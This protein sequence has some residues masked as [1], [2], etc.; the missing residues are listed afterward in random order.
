MESGQP[1]THLVINSILEYCNIIVTK[2]ELKDILSSP[3][4]T[5]FSLSSIEVFKNKLFP[6]IGSYSAKIQVPG[7][8]IFT[9]LPT[10]EKY[11]GSSSQL[12]KRL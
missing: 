2:E 6:L 4:Y 1:T 12:A 5:F 11:V 8:Y 3:Q 9:Y 7:V 10:G